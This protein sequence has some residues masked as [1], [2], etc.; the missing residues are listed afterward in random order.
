MFSLRMLLWSQLLLNK[1][2]TE[3]ARFPARKIRDSKGGLLAVLCAKRSRSEIGAS[4]DTAAGIVMG[5]S[6]A[7]Q[8][9]FLGLSWIKPMHSRI[10]T[11]I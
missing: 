11:N 6:N 1:L 8:Q 4:E 2:E 5:Y 9:Q 3:L 10:R 7:N